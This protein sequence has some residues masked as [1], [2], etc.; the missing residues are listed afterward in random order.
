MPIN[1]LIVRHLGEFGQAGRAGGH[2]QYDGVHRVRRARQSVEHAR[3]LLSEIS[4]DRLNGRVTGKPLIRE[5]PHATVF[6]IY[7]LE[8]LRNRFS[9]F[10]QFVDLFLIARADIKWRPWN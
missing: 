10:Q 4:A 7:D 9:N 5:G 6:P 1:K 3:L 2:A 8:N